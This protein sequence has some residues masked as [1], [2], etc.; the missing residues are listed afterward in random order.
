MRAGKNIILVGF[1]GTGKSTVGRLLA[2]KL[3][4]EFYDTDAEVERVTGLSVKEI[5]RRYGEVRFR[6]EEKAALKRLLQG[7]N[8]V[9]AT[10]GGIVL[11]PENRELMQARGV[12]VCLTATPEEIYRRV[13]NNDDRPLLQGVDAWEKLLRLWEERRPIYSLFPLQVK[14]DGKSREEVVAE[15]IALLSSQEKEEELEG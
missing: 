15:I 7:D 4:K 13:K 8:R 12:V 3:Q 2:K 6:S 10:G 14:T 9:I 1:M 11:D 5:F